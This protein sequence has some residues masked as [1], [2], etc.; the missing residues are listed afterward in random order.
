MIIKEVQLTNFQSYYAVKTFN[1]EDGLNIILGRN[2]QGKSKLFNAFK[3]IF[4]IDDKTHDYKSL[5]SKKSIAE[6]F[7]DC[8]NKV[9]VK[10]VLEYFDDNRDKK[11]LTIEKSFN[12]SNNGSDLEITRPIFRITRVESNGSRVLDQTDPE[13]LLETIFPKALRPYALLAGESELN[14][15][16]DS[17][18]I[19]NLINLLTS[20]RHYIK[21]SDKIGPALKK[22]ADTVEA[23]TRSNA[24]AIQ[25]YDELRNIVNQKEKSI[26]SLQNNIDTLL[27]DSDALTLRQKEIT[28]ILSSQENLRQIKDQIDNDRKEQSKYQANIKQDYVNDLFDK[29][30]ILT[31]FT[32]TFKKFSDVTSHA[33]LRKRE[34][35]A[36]HHENIGANRLKKSIQESLTNSATP[37]PIG[38]PGIGY[39]QEMIKD[40]ICKV[41]NR[42]FENDSPA[43]HYLLRHIQDVTQ[44]F[45]QVT[46]DDKLAGQK[47]LFENNFI[48][49]IIALRNVYASTQDS[50]NSLYSNIF[51]LV[52]NNNIWRQKANEIESKIDDNKEILKSSGIH[53]PNELNKLNLLTKELIQLTRDLQHNSTLVESYNQQINTLNKELIGYR[54]EKG[55]IENQNIT[56]NSKHQREFLENLLNA[57]N[58]TKESVFNKIIKEIEEKSNKI[59]NK[60]NVDSFTGQIEIIRIPNHKDLRATVQLVDDNRNKVVEPNQS[61]ITTV[62]IS[63]LFAISEIA[64]SQENPMIYPLMFDAPTSSFDPIKTNLFLSELHQTESQTIF[65]TMAFFTESEDAMGYGIDKAFED[66]Q[67]STAHLIEIEKPYEKSKLESI[68]TI[69]KKL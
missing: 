41:C 66:V 65:I 60:I 13:I 33:E 30:F 37:L 58:E 57:C 21:L 14:V 8:G 10:I 18:Q 34:I 53:D 32:S 9:A 25:K 5:V 22:S 59:L 67:R 64:R 52:N 38:V 26:N 42:E 20:S 50:R 44:S 45:S 31:N 54:A 62:N 43:H 24:R 23:E 16:S 51:E 63:I 49:Q 17:Q 2:G 3:F 40:K 46:I 39:V 11:K 12:A 7:K 1:F 69:V 35:E 19:T 55:R 15:F 61:L 4:N 47:P 68:N 48:N 6:N 29:D 36:E 28:D 27:V 56:S